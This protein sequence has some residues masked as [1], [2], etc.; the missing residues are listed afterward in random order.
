MKIEEKE[1]KALDFISSEF[2]WASYTSLQMFLFNVQI[3]I[4]VIK[5]EGIM[6]KKLEDGEIKHTMSK[7]ELLKIKHFILLDS[8]AK[9]MM[10]IEGLLVLCSVL[11][12]RSATKRD[13]P[14][15]MMRYTQQQIDAFIERFK[16]DKIS[17]WRIA[18]FPEL[19]KLQ[20]N[21]GLTR[22]ERKLIWEL[23]N[24]SCSVLRKALSSM[25]DFY[26]NNRV[27]YG[28]FKHGLTI[29][30]GYRLIS[31]PIDNVPSTF[32]C[33]L[34][35]RLQEPPSI[36]V[37]AVNSLPLE[38]AWFNT[39][40]V[41][42]Y[43]EMTFKKYSAIMADIKKFVTHIINNHLLWAENCGEDYFPL[44]K[45]PNGKWTPTVYTTKVWTEEQQKKTESVIT[46]IMANTYII[47]RILNFELNLKERALSR[48]KRSRFN[49]NNGT[50]ESYRKSPFSH[51]HS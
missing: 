38:F 8:L 21:C 47:N 40:S 11:S 6:L 35:H 27:L 24:D 12:D 51:N 29:I 1:R 14:Y 28:K 42:P 32:L 26:Q 3:M 43:W 22:D 44:E 18:G 50:R 37:K 7:E 36:C 30:S 39:I 10:I 16:R 48:L 20:R 46:K 33:A 45:Q 25:I 49:I 13:I 15:R 2:T 23:L 41:L 4:S 5:L 34:D 19:K 31:P 9:I 17:L